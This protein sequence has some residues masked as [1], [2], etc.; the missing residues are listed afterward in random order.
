MCTH[1]PGNVIINDYI[2]SANDN[3]SDP[4]N[5]GDGKFSNISRR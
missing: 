5:D 3:D 4:E 2:D 1:L